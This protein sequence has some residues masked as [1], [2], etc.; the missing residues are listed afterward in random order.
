MCDIC[1]SAE[2]T[3]Q[4]SPDEMRSAVDRGFDSFPS[5]LVNP[6]TIDQRS[7]G[8]YGEIYGSQDPK[9]NKLWF[10]DVDLLRQISGQRFGPPYKFA[11]EKERD[12]ELAKWRQWGESRK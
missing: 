5:L 9:T 3:L 6:P 10:S 1:M 12:A 7:V 2:E 4:M 11:G 8:L